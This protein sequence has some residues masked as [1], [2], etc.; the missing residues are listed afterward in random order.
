MFGKRYDVVAN[1]YQKDFKGENR[2]MLLARQVNEKEA[3]KVRKQNVNKFKTVA[4]LPHPQG[5]WLCE[6]LIL[7]NQK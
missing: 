4:R 5:V 6:N 3:D 2:F 1:N 7:S